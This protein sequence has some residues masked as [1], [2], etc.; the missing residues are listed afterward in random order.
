MLSNLLSL[1]VLLAIVAAVGLVIYAKKHG[2][3]W[4]AAL[5]ELTAAINS[6]KNAVV[7]AATPVGRAASAPAAAAPPPLV[8]GQAAT[9]AASSS[10]KTPINAPTTIAGIDTP[11]QFGAVRLTGLP[12]N[13]Y[14]ADK[15]FVI[16]EVSDSLPAGSD[17]RKKAQALINQA[18]GVWLFMKMF[19]Q[20]QVP[21]EG[22]DAAT[23]QSTFH[24]DGSGA[25]IPDTYALPP[26]V[27]NNV[28]TAAKFVG[29]LRTVAGATSALSTLPSPLPIGPSG[30][31][32][33]K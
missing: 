16:Q 3:S 27:A 14:W 2:E 18:A 30:A 12:A 33:G 7:T 23:Q 17:Q 6:H 26:K 19:V 8:T 32:A 1:L 22:M 24:G 4:L 9:T 20:A 11:D 29:D 13:S 31:V 25:F 10:S 28:G 21:A 5:K 15:R